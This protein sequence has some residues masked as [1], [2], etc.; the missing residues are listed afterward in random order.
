MSGFGQ[1]YNQITNIGDLT[2]GNYLIVGDGTSND[3]LMLNT[4]SPT[5]FIEFSSITNPGATITTGYTAANVFAVTVSAGVITIYNSNE[6]Y[7]SW[8]R[9]GV[10]GNNAIFYNGTVANTERWTPTV[11]DGLWSLASVNDPSR[12]L[13][14]NNGSP[15]F[16]AYTSNQVKL[17]L[18][19]LAAPAGPTVTYNGNGS[20]GGSVPTDSSSPYTSGDTV[21]VLGNTG[22][23]TKTCSTFDGWN[24]VADGSGSVYILNDTF[25]ITA[26]TTLY[27]QWTTPTGNTVTFN[28]NGGTGTMTPQINCA[29][30]NLTANTFTYT[31]NTFDEWN[32]ASD[33]SGTTYADGASYSFAANVTLY[34]QWDVYVG[35]CMTEGFEGGTNNPS[36]WANNSSYYNGG[37]ANTGTYKAGMN[38]NNDWIRTD[39]ISNPSTL[40]FWNKASGSTSN[41]SVIIQYSN[42]IGGPWTDTSTISANG[43]NTGSVTDS[44]S[45]TSVAL[46]LSGNY[47]IRWFMSAR[48]GGSFYFDDVAVFCGEPTPAPEMNLKQGSTS[49]ATTTVPIGSDNYDFGNRL[50]SSNTDIQFTIENTGDADL[51]LNAPVINGT[52]F[53]LQTA[54]SSTSVSGSSGTSTFTVR[55]TPNALGAFNGTI[56]IANN[57]ADENPYVINITGNGTNSNASDIIVNSTFVYN[58]NI[59][60]TAYQAPT[61][62]NT[63]QS[64][65]VFKFDIRDG[66]ATN[67]S[68]ALGTELTDIVFNVVNNANIRSA[69]LFNGNAL[70]SNAGAVAGNTISFSGLS[71]TAADNGT[72]SLSLRVTFLTTVTDNDQLQFTVSSAT[73]NTS[74]SVFGTPNAGGATSSTTGNRNRIEVVADRIAFTT[75]PG[76][77]SVNTNL[78][79]FNISAHDVFGN[80]DLDE[81]L[82]I[83]LTTSGIGMTAFSPYTLTAGNLAISNVQFNTSQTGINLTATTTGLAF[84]NTSTSSN[85]D[86]LDVATGTYRTTSNG[87][88]PS[89]TATWERLTGAGWNPA[90]PAANTTEL[91]IIRHT[92]T[93]RV[94]FAAPSPYTTMVVESGA[95]FDDAHNST[96]GSLLIKEGGEFIASDPAVDIDPTGTLTVENGG[97]LIINSS[98]LNNADGLFDGIENFEPNSTVEIRQYDN[99]STNGEDDLI[100]SDNDI[101]PNSEGYYFGNLFIN[102]TPSSANEDKALNLVG[103]IGTH[104]LCNNL[105]VIN[106]T[107]LKNVLL[108]N[109][110]ANVEIAGNVIVELNKFSFGAVGSSNL[111]HTVKGNIIVDGGIIDLNQNSSG[112]AT[113]LVN[114]EG[115]LIGIQGTIQ[116]T[117]G[118]CGIAFT[119]TALQNIDVADAVPYRNINTYV[120]NNSDVQLLNNNLKLNNSSTFTV[121][122]GGTLNF[123]WTADGSTPLL[124][125][126]GG[127]GSNTFDSDQGSILK[128]T[129]FDGLVKTTANAGNVQLSVSNK[130][131]SQAASF[132]YIGKE[133]Q[134]TGDGVS[135]GSTGKL[136][137]VNL[138]DNTK[139]LS[140]TNN[141]GIANATTLDPS[142]G[143]L[144]IQKGI[145]IGSNTG[146]FYGTGR[147]VMTDGE[148]RISTITASPLGNYLPQLNG[149][150]N[151][152]LTGGVVNLN[153]ANAIQI[154]AGAPTYYNLLFSGTN[155]FSTTPPIP[156]TPNYKGI[157]SATSVSNA[158]II[159]ENAIVN[160]ENRSLGATHNPSFTMLDNSRYIT[161]GGGT[162]PDTSGAYSL[163]PNTTIEFANFSGAG[164]VRIG[165]PLINYANIVVSG[166]D[167]SNNSL[168]TG[169]HFQTG[170]TFTVKPYA[171]FKLLNPAG[172]NGSNTTA[173]DSA[174][175]PTITLED[176]STV[177]YKGDAQTITDYTPEYKNLTISGTAIKTLG[178]PTDILIGEDLNMVSSAL[179]INSN[180]ALTV[181]EGV[182]VTGGNLTIEDSGSLIQINEFDT[183]SGPITM[184]RNASIRKLDYVYWSSPVE[185]YDVNNVYGTETPIDRI[186]RWNPTILN[187]LGTQGNWVTASGETMEKGVGYIVRGPNSYSTTNA[188][189]TAT[190]NNG[191]PFNGE[192]NVDV[193]RGTISG[194][195][196]DQWNLIGNPYPSA[197]DVFAFL[198][199]S[200]NTVLD[201]FVNIW[202]HG[203]LPSN[204]TVDPFYDNFGSNYTATDYIPYNKTGAGNAPGNIFIAAGQS[205]MVNLLETSPASSSITFNNSMRDKAYNN[206][207]FYRTFEPERHRIW[208]DLVSQ[209]QGT[210]RILVGYVEGATMERDRIYD[211]ITSV[212]STQNLYSIINNDPFIIQGRALPFIDTDAIP[213]GVK[214]VEQGN[215]HLAIAHIDGLFETDNQT[216][217]L[218]DNLLGFMHNLTN[219]PYSFTSEIGEFNSRFE[220]VFRDSALSINEEEVSASNVTIIEHSNGEVQFTVPSPYQIKSVEIMDLLGRT[221]YKLKGSSS[222]ETYDL[223]NLSQATYIAKISLTNGQ[224]ISKKAVKRK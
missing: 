173:I 166:F 185:G 115:D 106:N 22:S 193:F 6:G 100:D 85:F 70:I 210:N 138:L 163:S 224:V 71:Y 35:P 222:S 36:G 132:H 160:V 27:A 149:Y 190:F 125:S 150:G 168:T 215:Y 14:W 216:I 111:I 110:N 26:N 198:N 200:S 201:G 175:S 5:P 108:T 54:L 4:A 206:D 89:G 129:H 83:A 179:T 78:N 101:T 176:E 60:Y 15:R 93:S 75:Q 81:S 205:F 79:T 9:S 104:K 122:N 218:R 34:A 199:H 148:Y 25:T 28:N 16:A 97:T 23:L 196:D 24:T 194:D 49:Y 208:I 209:T 217:Y 167:V 219:Q 152:S 84:S 40:T 7:V 41:F 186:Y 134:V 86:I 88:W 94:S 183:N 90:T 155:T 45:Q 178:H 18:Y 39:V 161:D 68:D 126:N 188:N 141:I 123:N 162:K 139:T 221:I 189:I 13:Q 72:A 187:P 44:Y 66:G 165:S 105:T 136:V 50:V 58:S 159:S 11:T 170:G 48:S 174:N 57:D 220:I 135:N 77:T 127:S 145:V 19:K 46:N 116:S 62:T 64:I 98:T 92:I 53:S 182:F 32:T 151:Y 31:G 191:K 119:G 211:A 91:L 177:E 56:S 192:I 3:G 144:E 171:I 147:L 20:T 153:G 42:N 169:I 184:R 12:I 43:S 143:K 157:S 140:L 74:G 1:T 212:A 67:D 109:V 156:P 21:T 65:D 114:L 124:I 55:F 131:F 102:F 103:I 95:S 203:N 133:N 17:K 113:V 80:I 2:D 47:Y 33:G 51:T 181:D 128:I 10:T 130:T 61:I 180:N 195:I 117:D 142:G 214:I 158:I 120:K 59:N 29:A 197:I 213:L 112:S 204:I 172:F 37:D 8:G 207:Q 96:F 121:E 30:T 76:S 137:Y 107:F 154:L 99:D 164:V 146:D 82:S 63:G 38:S 202:T 73:A 52:G 69:A 118:D 87:T 223:S